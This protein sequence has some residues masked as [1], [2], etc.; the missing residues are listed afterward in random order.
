MINY[1]INTTIKISI[2][3][4]IIIVLFLFIRKDNIYYENEY[5]LDG[6]FYTKDKKELLTGIVK[7]KNN[8]PYS[9]DEFK[10]I[11]GLVDGNYKS[12]A[13]LHDTELLE[14]NIYITDTQLLNEIKKIIR[15]DKISVYY[16][17][18]YERVGY[19]INVYIK[20]IESRNNELKKIDAYLMYAQEILDFI[21]VKQ[22]QID[23][24]FI[25][26]DNLVYMYRD[27][28]FVFCY[29]NR[30]LESYFINK[31]KYKIIGDSAV[32]VP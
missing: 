6:Y 8:H 26:G 17:S 16:F 20:N 21:R 24:V 15:K 29:E 7:Y 4:I 18:N 22:S 1:K 2:L 11:N 30:N 9:T 13:D 5:L 25:F 12:Y 23:I 27:Y 32:Y 19:I 28:G 3:I 14:D 31:D 10:I